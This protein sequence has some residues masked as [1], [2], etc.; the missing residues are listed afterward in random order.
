M[1]VFAKRAAIKLQLQSAPCN[2]LVL[3]QLREVKNPQS[4]AE[5]W[6]DLVTAFGIVQALYKEG[7]ATTE[8]DYL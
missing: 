7:G 2:R 8:E 1:S 5:L 4:M 6:P 3:D